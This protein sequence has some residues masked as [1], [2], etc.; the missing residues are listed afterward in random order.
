[1]N[2]HVGSATACLWTA[3]EGVGNIDAWQ[4]RIV[5]WAVACS[6]YY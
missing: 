6:F 2:G 3:K 4:G 1:L 5:E